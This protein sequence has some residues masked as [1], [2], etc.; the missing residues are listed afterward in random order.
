M[1]IIRHGLLKATSLNLHLY[2]TINISSEIQIFGHIYIHLCCLRR[3]N[4]K[5][6]FPRLGRISATRMHISDLVYVLYFRSQSNPTINS[7]ENFVLR[8]EAKESMCTSILLH[9]MA[10]FSG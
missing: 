8:S 2:I 10:F 3:Y 6:H 4:V 1:K 5:V 7:A 9:D